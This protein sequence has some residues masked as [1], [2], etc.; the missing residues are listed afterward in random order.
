MLA[1]WLSP[2]TLDVPNYQTVAATL[3]AGRRLYG[4]TPGI[5]PYPPPWALWEVAAALIA[6]ATA[7]PFAFVIRLPILAADLAVVALL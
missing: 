5:Y 3:L 6:N 7:L 2:N 1:V 4:D